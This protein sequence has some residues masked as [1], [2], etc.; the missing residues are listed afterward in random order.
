MYAYSIYISYRYVVVPVPDGARCIECAMAPRHGTAGMF[1]FTV[2]FLF[3]A[4]AVGA[5]LLLLL[6]LMLVP[7][8]V[9]NIYLSYIVTNLSL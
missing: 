9:G 1:L 7:W 8:M 5:L 3:S 2:F 4:C 6:P